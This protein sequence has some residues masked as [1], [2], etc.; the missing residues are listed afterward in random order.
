[1]S[2]QIG[3]DILGL[4][5]AEDRSALLRFNRDLLCGLYRHVMLV[6]GNDDRGIDVAI[7][8]ERRRGR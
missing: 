4:V 3:A 1:M 2:S 6:D 5:E 8:Y 7:K